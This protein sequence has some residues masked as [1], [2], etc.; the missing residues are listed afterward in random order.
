MVT[1]SDEIAKRLIGLDQKINFENIAGVLTLKVLTEY[2]DGHNIDAFGRLRVSNSH[3]VFH[4][5]LLNGDSQPLIWDE[6]LESGTMA[7]SGPTGD[8][9]YIDFTSTNIT[10]GVRTRQTYQRFNYQPGKSQMILM[11]G[12]LDLASG[13][14][15]GCRR[16]IGPFNDSNGVFFED[17]AGTTKAVIVSSDSGTPVETSVS[18]DKWNLD[19]LSGTNDVNNKSGI[20]ADWTKSQIFVTDFQWLSAGRVRVGLEIN[21][22]IIYVHE[23]N[24]ANTANIP[25][26]S[27]PNLPLRY[28]IETTSSSGI[29]SM[30]CI[31]GAVLSEGGVEELGITR[32]KSTEGTH[33]A[34]VTE[35]T[36]YALLGVRLKT[37]HLDAV[38]KALNV[39]IQ[40]QSASST[41]EWALIYGCKGVPVT[42]ANTFTYADLDNTAIQFATGGSTNTVTGGTCI[43]GGFGETGN[44]SSGD[45]SSESNQLTQ[46]GLGSAIDGERS[47]IILAVRPIAGSSAVN[48]EGSLKWR[49][50][51]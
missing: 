24:F 30:R 42:V 45:N 7:T 50:V 21:G 49:E 15:T 5:K 44:N 27:T 16:Q 23:F 18:Q 26:S 32:Y 40:V 8:K 6:E 11:T 1:M 17:N 48:V 20:A 28:R 22:R 4:S 12:V 46:L 9:P 41:L 29:C 33:L 35:G 31:C 2:H 19:N 38:V 37:T 3:T 51:I 25:W 34:T 13:I 36:L 47:E 10:E 39:A 43:G 14:T